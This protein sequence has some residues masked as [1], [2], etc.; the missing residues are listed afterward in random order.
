MRYILLGIA[1]LLSSTGCISKQKSIDRG[2]AGLYWSAYMNPN[3]QKYPLYFP[4]LF[5]TRPEWTM[6]DLMRTIRNNQIKSVEELLPLLPTSFLQNYALVY[7]S[8]S[9]QKSNPKNPRVI[10]YGRDAQLVLTFNGDKKL[11]GY[12]AL[13]V[14]EFNKE[15]REFALFEIKLDGKNVPL[16]SPKKNPGKC[17]SCHHKD[18]R[19]IWS[20]YPKW[21]GVFQSHEGTVL[22]NVWRNYL[23]SARFVK[24]EEDLPKI[25]KEA[26]L[27]ADYLKGKDDHPRYKHLT[28]HSET[29]PSRVL[30]NY[31]KYLD[32]NEKEDGAFDRLTPRPNLEIGYFLSEMNFMR[33][34]RKIERHPKSRA[35]AYALLAATSCYTPGDEDDEKKQLFP[36]TIDKFFPSDFKFKRSLYDIATDSQNLFRL[37]LYYDLELERKWLGG[38]DKKPDLLKLG[39]GATLTAPEN[40]Q[41]ILSNMGIETLDWS[42]EFHNSFDYKDGVGDWGRFQK[43]IWRYALYPKEMNPDLFKEFDGDYDYDRYQHLKV[44]R[45]VPVCRRLQELSISA[46]SRGNR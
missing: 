18:P 41:F 46:I 13:E 3:I 24:I 35:F 26:S 37:N 34:M 14:M 42:L 40:L 23:G 11:A 4:D 45:V 7:D 27:Y 32:L 9:I 16:D 5:D 39:I 29:R 43:Y 44:D 8:R 30:E 22:G 28:V 12:K 1:V 15:K 20:S 31:V 6:D 33:V 2:P 10:M 19:P 17:T 25:E 38:E 21:P 36:V